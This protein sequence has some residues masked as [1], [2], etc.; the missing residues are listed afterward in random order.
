MLSKGH[1][2]FTPIGPA[3]AA[4]QVDAAT[5]RLRTRVN[6]EVVQDAGAD[7]LLFGFAELIADLT[8][9][10]TLERGDVIL[11]GTPAGTG[12]VAPGDVVEVELARPGLIGPEHRRRKRSS[13]WPRTGPCR[14]PRRPHARSPP[15]STRLDP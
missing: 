4:D 5:L 6:G 11:T 7:E 3:V 10:M 14:A 12:V 13:H 9:F 1:D 15:A 8:R 2:G